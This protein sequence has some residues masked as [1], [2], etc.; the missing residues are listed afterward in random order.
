MEVFRGVLILRRIAA[1][2]MPAFEAKTQVYPC[3]PD[4]QTILTAIRAGRDLSDMVTMCTSCS[5]NIFLSDFLRRLLVNLL[6]LS[7]NEQQ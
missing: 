1:A 7:F 2:N 6:L 3:I 4:F 5:H